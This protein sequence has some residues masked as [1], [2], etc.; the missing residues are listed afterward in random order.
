MI[1]RNELEQIKKKAKTNPF[2]PVY[3]I[4]WFGTDTDY[5][6][7]C[8]NKDISRRLEAIQERMGGEQ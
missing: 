4:I 5:M 8:S 3:Q 2:W 6:D 7:T 1:N